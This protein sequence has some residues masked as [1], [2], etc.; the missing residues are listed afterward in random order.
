M[1]AN[2]KSLGA[3]ENCRS[4]ASG[5]TCPFFHHLLHPYPLRLAALEERSWGVA[6]HGKA[7]HNFRRPNFSRAIVYS[8]TC[9]PPPTSRH[10]PLTPSEAVADH[11][12][13]ENVRVLGARN[14]RSGLRGNYTLGWLVARLNFKRPNR[15]Y[16]PPYRSVSN[17]N[18]VRRR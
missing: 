1:L 7:T 15:V 4:S 14:E 3:R 6:S 12:L 16:S 17:P 9:D 2:A 8:R 10:L 11:Q 18:N 5:I 13:A